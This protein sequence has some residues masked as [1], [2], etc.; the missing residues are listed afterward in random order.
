M[1][2]H[3]RATRDLFERIHGIGHRESDVNRPRNNLLLK[4]AP[5]KASDSDNE[6][7]QGVIREQGEWRKIRREQGD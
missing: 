7:H 4:R 1:G 2:S 3:V 5:I 6:A